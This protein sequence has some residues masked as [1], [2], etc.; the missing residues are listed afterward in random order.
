[1]EILQQGE[2]GNSLRREEIP[3][4]LP[5][6][7]NHHHSY[8]SMVEFPYFDGAVG[9]DPCSWLRKCE[10]YFHYNHVT[11]PEQKLEEA[12]LHLNGRAEAWYFS[13][14]LSKGN[15]RWPE[16]CEEICKRFQDADN[17][18]FNLI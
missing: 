11:L 10:R 8:N 17:S 4:V 7:R 12:V 9:A 2:P 13:Y 1:M 18:K 14:Q 16:F 6:D 5:N 15:V 3:V